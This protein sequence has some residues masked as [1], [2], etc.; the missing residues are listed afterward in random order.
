MDESQ[1]R[2]DVPEV[3]TY[4]VLPCEEALDVL[5]VDA[6]VAALGAHCCSVEWNATVPTVTYD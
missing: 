6:V 5:P 1:A 4:A 2:L 3:P